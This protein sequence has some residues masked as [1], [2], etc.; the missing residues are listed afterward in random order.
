MP[1]S[2]IERERRN[3]FLCCS[4]LALHLVLICRQ[5]ILTEF[6]RSHSLMQKLSSLEQSDPTNF[7]Y[8]LRFRIVLRLNFVASAACRRGGWVPLSHFRFFAAV[9]GEGSLAILAIPASSPCSDWLVKIILP[10]SWRKLF[11]F[12]CYRYPR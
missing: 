1:S 10:S 3:A 6:Q 4:T 12:S 8:S 11:N 7:T 9:T 2:H 5:G